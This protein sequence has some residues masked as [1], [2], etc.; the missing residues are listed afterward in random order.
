MLSGILQFVLL[1]I[2]FKWFDRK[3]LWLVIPSIMLV[4]A[5]L[6]A[7]SNKTSDTSA[8][9]VGF[10]GISISFGLYKTLEY[11]LRGALIEMVR[12]SEHVQ[13]SLR[14]NGHVHDEANRDGEWFPIYMWLMHAQSLYTSYINPRYMYPWRMM[15]LVF[16]EKK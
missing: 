8:A 13:E 12:F 14:F 1:P 10:N 6:M 2:A 5:V 4:S 7:T 3:L 9:E 11:S 16:W 15:R